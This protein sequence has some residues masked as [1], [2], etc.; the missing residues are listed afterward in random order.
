MRNLLNPKWLFVINT[1]PIVVLF[2]LLFGQFN[3]IKSLLDEESVLLWKTL[4][5]TLGIIGLLNFIYSVFL[6][7]RKENVPAWYA[8]VALFCYIPFIYV[9]AYYI[10]MIVPSSIPQWMISDNVFLYVGTFLMPTLAYSLF[11]LVIHFTPSHKEHKAWISF[12]MAIGIPITGYLFAQIILPL[13]QNVEGDFFTHALVVFVIAMTLVFLFF[14]VRGVFI[15]MT[16]KTVVWQRYQ[17]VWKIPIVILFPL[18]GLLINNGSLGDLGVGEDGIFGNFSN[19]WFYVLTLL[20]GILICL[21]NLENKVY[22]LLVFVG[23]SATFTFTLYFFLVFLPFLPVSI[24]AVIAIGIGFLML[25]PLLLFIIHINEL[26]KDFKY[27]KT[28][29]PQK[30]VICLSLISFLVIPAFLTAIYLRDKVVLKETLDYVYTPDYSE[31]YSI[32]TASLRKT[33][34]AIK[35]NKDN[36]RGGLFISGTPYLSS[37]FNWVV[38]GN[39]TLSDSKIREIEK[40]FFDKTDIVNRSE[41][42]RN[43]SVSISSISTTSVFDEEQEVWKSWVDLELTNNNTNDWFDEYATTIDLPTACWISDYYLFVGDKKE[44]GILAEKKSAMWVFSQIRGGNRDPGILY[45]LTGT[46]VAFRVFPFSKNE[47]RK[48]GIE[49]LHKEPVQLTIDGRLVELGETRQSVFESVET[50]NVVYVSSAEK[51]TLKTVT[52]QPYFHFLLD[53][54]EGNKSCLNDFEERINKT[55]KDNRSLAENA[56]ISFVNSYVE[57]I[58]LDENWTKQYENQGFVGGFYLDRAIRTTLFD[59]YK[60]KSMAYPI[61]VVVTDNMTEAV[62]NKDF[63]DFQF[64][65]PENNLFYNLD[66][67]GTLLEHSLID[68][69]SE[70]LPNI[71][72]ECKFCETVLEYTLSENAVMYLPNDNIASII[73][74][75]ETFDV[76]PS[77]ISEKNWKSALT[78]QGQW[79]SQILHPELSDNEWLSLVKNSFVSKVMTPVTSYLVVENEAQ[80]EMLRKKQNQALTGNK[81]L[82]LGEDVDQMSEP[83]LILLGVLLI[84]TLWYRD[85]RKSIE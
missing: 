83:S 15:F 41:F 28:L 32:N 65:F 17:L 19:P 34:E 75:N 39:F 27:F 25:T 76:L 23:R 67:N 20:N 38:M 73:L 26:S 36:N 54:S 37:Y 30:I 6:T 43:A 3:I 22:R 66:I 68:N 50:E 57:T 52:R 11:V 70:Q 1:L 72:R 82:D 85:R 51:N 84:L 40:I 71:N 49:F 5:F 42:I 81:S 61:I 64:A 12:L 69:P 2:C 74:K 63:S 16:K 47:V 56:K 24:F 80:K 8:L 59:T 7:F 35:Q 60:S 13:W 10:D 58:P 9:Y 55:I 18:L 45:Y 44:S 77:E 31:Q 21:P 4:S 48:T 62:L 79:Q 33:L 46:K 78:M 29:L 14:L 53:V